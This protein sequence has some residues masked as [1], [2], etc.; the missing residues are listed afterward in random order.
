MLGN[1]INKLAP[2]IAKPSKTQ[3]KNKTKNKKT[4]KK[5]KT[6]KLTSEDSFIDPAIAIPF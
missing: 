2:T 1:N 6:R 5:S 4:Q 3:T